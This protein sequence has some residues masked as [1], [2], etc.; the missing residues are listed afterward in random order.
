[1]KVTD[2]QRAALGF[3]SNNPGAR[4]IEIAA[5]AGASTS[6]DN[7]AAFLGRLIDAGLVEVVLTAEASDVLGLA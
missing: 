5:A 4:V 3:I 6:G 2:K 1:M 7:S